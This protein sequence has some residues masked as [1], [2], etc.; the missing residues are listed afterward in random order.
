[1]SVYVYKAKKDAEKT[2]TGRINAQT[3]EEAIDLIHQLGF[4]P[5]SVELDS[6]EVEAKH[7]KRAGKV[8]SKEV[9]IFSRQLANL[10]KSGISV[11]RA[12]TIIESQSQ[13]LS[14]KKIISQISYD[15]KNGKSLSDS[16][17][18]YPKVFSSLYVTMVRAGEES[19]NLQEM[20]VNVA[21]YQRKQEE[22]ASKVKMAL[23][24]PILMASLGLITVYFILT[25]V[26]PKMASLFDSLGDDLPLVTSIL[27][28]IST[29][30]STNWL[31]V[32]I[33]LLCLV[34]LFKQWKSTKVGAKT[35]GQYILHMPLFGEI[36]L[37]TELSRFCR[38]LVLLLN[39][40]ISI[41]R[42]LEITI[43]ILSN[44]LIKNHL[45]YCRD[46]LIAG[47][48]FG[49]SIKELKDIPPMMGHLISIGEESGNITEVLK[50]IAD[51][52]EQET[53]EQ[54]KMVTTLLEPIMILIVGLMIGF[55]VFAI[56]LPIF[57]IDML[58]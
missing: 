28:K 42:S 25:Y 35:F 53:S 36:I 46:D 23:A 49:E 19:G 1:M 4:L 17:G 20:L 48:S 47:G 2:V 32:F 38:A 22:I 45:S 58:V 9:Y 51:T 6:S 12:L 40:G 3:E 10:L 30:L 16:L 26:L 8:R 21:Q 52:Y 27:F 5:V 7:F 44:Q 29:F 50:E 41:V 56:L 37:K 15:V 13:N 54:I 55:I 39:S 57:Q 31:L 33:V 24:Y 34:F 14:F 18:D 11:L 43:P